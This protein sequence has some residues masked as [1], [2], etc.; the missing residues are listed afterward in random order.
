MNVRCKP[1]IKWLTQ[2][3]KKLH[4][5]PAKTHNVNQLT[6]FWILVMGR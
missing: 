3:P 2:I 1:N 5:K 4:S 6:K